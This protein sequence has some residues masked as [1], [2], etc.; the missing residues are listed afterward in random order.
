MRGVMESEG[1][2][3][4]AGEL[5]VHEGCEKGERGGGDERGERGGGV[6]ERDVLQVE[7]N[8]GGVVCC[9]CGRG[10]GDEVELCLVEK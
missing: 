10:D 9:H 8:L 5:V 3:G 6:G 7:G 2:E 1:I 4:D